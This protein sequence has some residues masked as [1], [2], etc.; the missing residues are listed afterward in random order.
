FKD[1]C[2][3]YHTQAMQITEV[4]GVPEVATILVFY[5]IWRISN[6]LWFK[7]KKIEQC[8]RDQGLT[9]VKEM[10]QMQN[11][12]TS[13]P[14]N[15]SHDI[16]SRVMPFFYKSWVSSHGNNFFTWI[17]TT[18]VVHVTEPTLVREAL[19]NY[20]KYIKVT[21]NPLRKSLATGLFFAEGDEWAKHR[22]I[23]N[24]AFHVEKLKHMESSFYETCSEMMDK[25][26]ELMTG[27]NSCEV[28]IVPYFC[29]FSEQAEMMDK[30]DKS[31][32]VPGSRFLPTRNNKRI[33]EIAQEVRAIIYSIIDKRV[34][35]MKSGEIT[36]KD[37]LLGM[38]LESNNKEIKEGGNKN[39]GL[40]NEDIFEECKL[41][42]FAGYHRICIY[43]DY[44]F[45]KPS[46]GLANTLYPVAAT[47]RRLIHEEVKLGN[48]TLPARTIIQ[49]NNLL[50]YH[51]KK[52][53]VLYLPFGTGP[54]ICI[55][56]NFAMLEMKMALAMILQRF[57]FDLSPSYSHAPQ[58]VL[59]LQ[60]QFGAHLILHKL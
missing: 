45:T 24:P 28:D 56:Q 55:G 10:E 33:K 30:I 3:F 52:T 25:W 43:L 35:A 54:R 23:I 19:V 58:T 36:S 46:Q 51:D 42:Y 47:T 22:K 38:L 8:L 26:E 50:F 60:P 14:M 37:D 6:W 31:L 39:F 41:F 11:E 7:P 13:K 40:S 48:L 21:G 2:L 4:F 16:S 32:Y 9:D 57:S 17:G 27:E 18:P 20:R 44:D 53:W 59:S 29:S 5:I 34:A 49:L 12:V 1:H 15:L